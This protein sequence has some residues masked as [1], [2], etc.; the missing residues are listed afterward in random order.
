VGLVDIDLNQVAAVR[1]R[2]PVLAHRR[3][4]PAVTRV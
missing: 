4:V 2:V 1:S 3:A